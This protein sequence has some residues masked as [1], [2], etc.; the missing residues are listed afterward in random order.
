MVV[1]ELDRIAVFNAKSFSLSPPAA[2]AEFVRM[3]T[4]TERR[5]IVGSRIASSS[6]RLGEG[7]QS[8]LAVAAKSASV[9]S[10]SV[11]CILS[12]TS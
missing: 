12:E 10:S 5:S 1:I 11:F 9:H 6:S 4:L 2:L 7:M 3:S 8:F